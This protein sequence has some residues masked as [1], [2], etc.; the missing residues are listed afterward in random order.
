VVGVVCCVGLNGALFC[1]LCAVACFCGLVSWCYKSVWWVGCV[2]LW[3]IALAK[4]WGV[5]FCG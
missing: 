1:C 3:G 4:G 2:V 5:V